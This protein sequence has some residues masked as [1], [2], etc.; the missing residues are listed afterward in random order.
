MGCDP[1][2]T[3][4]RAIAKRLAQ[5]RLAL[6]LSQIK[7]AKRAGVNANTWNQWEKGVNRPELNKGMQ[8]ADKLGITLDWIYR[9]ALYTL[10]H[11]LAQ[12]IDE[13]PDIP[14][15]TPPAKRPRAKPKERQ[16]P[17]LVDPQSKH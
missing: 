17:R 3:H 5:T 2:V 9:G 6:G 11:E 15:P 16:R 4:V 8:I 1:P 13:L 12:R 7:V 10:A 14:F